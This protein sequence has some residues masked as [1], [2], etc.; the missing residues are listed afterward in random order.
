MR[1]GQES[2]GYSVWRRLQ[3]GLI[4][5]FQNF[6]WAYKKDVDKPFRRA[7]VKAQGMTVLN[8]MRVGLD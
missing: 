4:E 8:Q 3:E 5:A 7:V 1:T 6:R 2:W